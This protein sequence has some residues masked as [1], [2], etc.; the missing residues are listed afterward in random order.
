M[1]DKYQNT[2]RWREIKRAI[3]LANE[4]REE[5]RRLRQMAADADYEADRIE[6]SVGL[7]PIA[8][9]EIDGVKHA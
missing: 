3:W 4:R 5:A 1:T 8:R 9:G 6:A 2:D 7:V